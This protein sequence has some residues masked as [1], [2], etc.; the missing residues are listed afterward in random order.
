M[1][2]RARAGSW[3]TLAMA[4]VIGHALTFGALHVLEPDLSPVSSIISDYGQTEHAWLVTGAYFLFAAIWGCIVAATSSVPQTVSVTVGRLL[5]SLAVA[6]IVIAALVPSSADPRTP[7]ILA[8]ALNLVR[9][10]LF[11]GLVLLSVGLRNAP[12]W[13]D[14]AP[15]LVTLSLIAVLLLILTLGPLFRSGYGG[16]GQRT[17]FILLYGWV[18]LFGIRLV[19]NGRSQGLAADAGA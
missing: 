16:A 19:K 6:G 13:K 15:K 17:L 11:L 4:G 3:A 12:P 10:G 2:H 14:L 9:P 8:M 5:L 1:N 7:S 18:V